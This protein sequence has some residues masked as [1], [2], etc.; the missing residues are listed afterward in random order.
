MMLSGKCAQ[1]ASIKCENIQNKNDHMSAHKLCIPLRI[2][3]GKMRNKFQNK[4]SE[5]LKFKI[6][7]R[8]ICKTS[9]LNFFIA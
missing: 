7:A 8:T 3:K 2:I 1:N 4:S 6:I 9:F 5:K